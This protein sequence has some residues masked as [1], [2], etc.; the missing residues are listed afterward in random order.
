MEC[1]FELA[2]GESDVI[3]NGHA[4]ATTIQLIKPYVD[5]ERIHGKDVKQY[6]A[7]H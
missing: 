4:M 1:A 2:V 5:V 6:E 7:T 3:P